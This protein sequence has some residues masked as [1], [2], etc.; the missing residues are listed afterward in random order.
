MKKSTY[1]CPWKE[2]RY[3]KPQNLL[4]MEFIIDRII[5]DWVCDYSLF[6]VLSLALS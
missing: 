6:T 2:N 1:T 5:D 3:L 4:Y